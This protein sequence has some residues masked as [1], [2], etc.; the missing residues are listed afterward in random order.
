M[1]L[2]RLLIAG[3]I[4]AIGTGGWVLYNRV[5]VKR[6]AGAANSDPLLAHVRA[7]IPTIVYFTTPMCQPCRTLQRPALDNLK[8]ELG[9]NIQVIQVDSCEQT[10]VADRCGVFSA[11]T[12][13]VLHSTLRPRQVTLA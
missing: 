7:G 10:D 11:P 9:S 4:V 13:F 3:L 1:I 8:D 12:T 2:E 6:L 5:S